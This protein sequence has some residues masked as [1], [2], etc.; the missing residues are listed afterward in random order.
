M[1]YLHRSPAALM[2]WRLTGQDG[3]RPQDRWRPALFDN[4]AL[5]LPSSAR[6]ASGPTLTVGANRRALP[7]DSQ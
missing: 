2:P 4:A 6:A 3:P 7:L 1:S 5:Q